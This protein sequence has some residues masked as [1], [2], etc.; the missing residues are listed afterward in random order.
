MADEVVLGDI[1][2]K[3]RNPW[4]VFLLAIVTF[5][6]YALVWWYKIN[7]EMRHYGIENTPARATL[8][9]SLGALLIVPP[10]VSLY[11]TAERIRQ[12]QVK[13]GAE[14]RMI[15][16][17]GLLLSIVVGGFSMPYYQ[18]QL[19]KAWDAEVTRGATVTGG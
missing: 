13:S 2:Y 3:R 7:N 12:T 19:N 10:F 6:I 17:L 15:P 9:I 8:A 4:G 18:S 5:G 11:N 14:E 1:H 16:V